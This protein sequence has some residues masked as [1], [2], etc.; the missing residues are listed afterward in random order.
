[1]AKN[2]AHNAESELVTLIRRIIREEL[3]HPADEGKKEDLAGEV[4][5][6][7]HQVAA[8]LELSY[9]MVS[10]WRRQELLVGHRKY[11]KT[12]F[13]KHEVLAAHAKVKAD[14]LA[15]S[16]QAFAA[17]QAKKEQARLARQQAK[18][19]DKG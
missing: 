18:Q 13:K 1:M 3:G 14:A 12:L 2:H 16:Q 8:L 19:Q 6:T 9:D 10:K 5:L 17:R 11:G 4:L 7:H 15:A